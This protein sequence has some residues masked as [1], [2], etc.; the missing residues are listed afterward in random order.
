M[1]IPGQEHNLFYLEKCYFP[2]QCT[3]ND[4]LIE[5]SCKLENQYNAVSL[6]NYPYLFFSRITYEMNDVECA[7]RFVAK[8][9]KWV[10]ILDLSGNK[11]TPEVLACFVPLL[12]RKEFQFLNL[13]CHDDNYVNPRQIFEGLLTNTDAVE[14]RYILDKIIS[15]SLEKVVSAPPSPETKKHSEFYSL[16]THH[17]STFYIDDEGEDYD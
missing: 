15:V 16:F 14:N 8:L 12:Q 5:L 10:E 3:S 4:I 9:P 11:F 17:K 2:T 1:I 6:I 7:K 13:T